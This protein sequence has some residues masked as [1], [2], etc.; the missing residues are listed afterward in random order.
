[1]TNIQREPSS[2][3]DKDFEKEY[4][5]IEGNQD[6]RYQRE[7]ELIEQDELKKIQEQQEDYGIDP[8]KKQQS[9]LKGFMY[10]EKS[11]VAELKS[12]P[13]GIKKTSF[14][15]KT[16]G[17]FKLHWKSHLNDPTLQ[18]RRLEADENIFQI[19]MP[20]LEDFQIEQKKKAQELLDLNLIDKSEFNK[21]VNQSRGKDKGKQTAVALRQKQLF[22]EP[23]SNSQN[24]IDLVTPKKDEQVYTEDQIFSRLVNVNR[25]EDFEWKFE[26]E[27]F[28]KKTKLFE[29]DQVKI[30]NI[31]AIYIN[32]RWKKSEVGDFIPKSKE[33]LQREAKEKKKKSSQ[34]QTSKNA[35]K[36]SDSD[37]D[38]EY[39]EKQKLKASS[40]LCI[41]DFKKL[42]IPNTVMQDGMIF[43]W[44]EKEYISDIIKHLE[45][46]GFAYVE[47]VC[48]VML[49]KPMQKGKCHFHFSSNFCEIYRS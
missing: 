46:Q 33:Q 10:K 21:I 41:E 32:P 13:T 22:E 38:R 25:V 39:E 6:R 17:K 18:P 11:G 28:N 43:I 3:E 1:M 23:K 12:N 26:V 42:Q 15:V 27:E 8:T 19:I 31:E 44:V 30:E 47:N 4:P 36:E 34:S 49:D 45:S 48:H 37:S 5:I 20:W 16:C 29:K 35:K 14:S 40:G 9:T 2:E 24:P 7:P